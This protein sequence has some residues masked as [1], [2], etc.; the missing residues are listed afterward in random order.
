MFYL[1]GLKPGVYTLILRY[2]GEPLGEARPIL[3]L[4]DKNRLSPRTL[5]PVSLSGGG[6]R[7]IAKVLMPQAI[8]WNQDDWFS[9]TS[10]SVD[11]VTKFRVP[12]GITWVERKADLP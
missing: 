12:E 4:P 6:R 8:L 3:Y 7:V 10:E 1:R 11:T 9:G 5:R 2:R